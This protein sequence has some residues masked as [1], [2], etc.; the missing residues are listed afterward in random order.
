MKKTQEDLKFTKSF[1]SDGV[2]LL[3]DG[4]MKTEVQG[5]GL[6]SERFYKLNRCELVSASQEGHHE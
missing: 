5:D 2:K 6:Y 3:C 1:L 4:V